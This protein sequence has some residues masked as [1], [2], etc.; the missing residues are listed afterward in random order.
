VQSGEPIGIVGG[1]SSAPA[2]IGALAD[3]LGV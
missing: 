3:R 2:A 1:Y